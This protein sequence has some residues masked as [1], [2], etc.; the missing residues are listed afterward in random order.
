MG[1]TAA[2]S[3]ISQVL[4]SLRRKNMDLEF[5]WT[6]EGFTAGG[7]K[8]YQPEELEIVRV[9]RFEGES[10]PSDM[11]VIY[12]LRAADGVTGYSLDAYGAYSSHDLESGYN[13]FIRRIPES[14]HDQQIL[15][16]L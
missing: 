10:D 11:A 14:D 9:F 2:M 5:R 6:P 4:E 1:S 13:N 7:A 15:F 16:E 8:Y 12:V 3:T